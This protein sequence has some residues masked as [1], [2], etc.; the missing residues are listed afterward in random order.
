MIRHLRITVDG[1]AYDVTVEDLAPG[2]AGVAGPGLPAPTPTALPSHPT[3]SALPAA[4]PP[5]VHAGNGDIP[6]PLA[7]TVVTVTVSVG[8][9]V[10]E[11]D[12]LMVLESM[13]MNTPI[14]APRGG[15]VGAISVTPGATVT[16]GQILLTLA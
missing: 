15:T 12:T 8:Q 4:S 6:S 11:G 3:P 16:E 1:T 7:G 2:S 9:T 5:A 10:T 13:K 14:N